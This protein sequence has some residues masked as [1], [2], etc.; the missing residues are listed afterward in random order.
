MPFAV[1]Q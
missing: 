1:Y